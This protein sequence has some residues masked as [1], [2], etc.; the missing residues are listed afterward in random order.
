MN[1]FD[2]QRIN[3]FSNFSAIAPLFLIL[4]IFVGVATNM[5]EEH[6]I[7]KEIQIMIP[8]NQRFKKL[9]TPDNGTIRLIKGKVKVTH[10]AIKEDSVIMVNRKNIEGKPGFHLLVSI[11]P[12]ESFTIKSVDDEGTIETEDYGEVF[13]KIY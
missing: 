13:F 5:T 9:Q 6:N 2:T 4:I 3:S 11:D 1:P 7:A 12:N 8:D 10:H